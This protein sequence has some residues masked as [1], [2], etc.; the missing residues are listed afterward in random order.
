MWQELKRICELQPA[1]SS[2]NTLAMQERGR[3]L[4]K[5]VKP[6][7]ESMQ[8]H[9]APKLGKFGQDFL[10]EASDG[11]G[12]KTELPWVRFASTSMS[13]AATEGFYFV[14]HFSTDGSAVHLTIGSGSS[15][16]KGGSFVERTDAEI[17]TNTAWARSIILEEFGTLNPFIDEH[18]FGAR[19]PLPKSFERATVVSKRIPCEDLEKTGFEEILRLAAERLRGIY[20]AQSSGRDLTPA[21]QDEAAI[22]T[23]INPN[24]SAGRRQGLGLSAPAKRAVELR[25]MELARQHL[26]GDGFKV[27][28]RSSN[29]P[30]DLEAF[31]DDTTIKVEV[32]GTTSDSADAILM[33]RNEVDLHTKEKGST[34]LIIVSRI[35]LL[36]SEGGYEAKEGVLEALMG[37]DIG[38]WSCEPTAFRVIRPIEND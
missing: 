24:S 19:R 28:D 16:Y 14:M 37:W 15:K 21:D 12:R 25:A 20:E 22:G 33:T 8:G 29:H 11:V 27:H 26:E 2:K 31:K 35:R 23:I 5:E 1:Y 13:P 18:D 9:L 3:I 10:V 34:C 36:K 6:A 7:I 30:F 17:D 32:K 4:R 38:Q